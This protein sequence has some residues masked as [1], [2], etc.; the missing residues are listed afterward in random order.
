MT[1]QDFID[2]IE[3]EDKD[4][5]Y[6]FVRTDNGQYYSTYLENGFIAI[7]WDYVTVHDITT[8]TEEE[9]K[10]KISKREKQRESQNDISYKTQISRIYNKLIRFK[11]L[12]KGDIIVIPDEGSYNLAFGE[13]IEDHIFV[14][15]DA[16]FECRYYKRRKVKWYRSGPI[17]SFDPH[18]RFIKRNM[19]AI[20]DVESFRPYIDNVLNFLYKRGD[21]SHYVIEVKLTENI[22][23]RAFTDLVNGIEKVTELISQSFN[24]D[25]DLTDASI[26]LQLQ[27]PGMIEIIDKGS[28]LMI[29]A[30]FLSFASCGNNNVNL[31]PATTEKFKDI[32]QNNPAIVDTCLK[33]FDKLEADK[34]ELDKL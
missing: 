6:W 20:S 18:L 25:E 3:K 28:R 21:Y 33:A 19:H 31:D 7:G 10:A 26:K 29:L 4:R 34:F 9:V 16:G 2:K 12:K 17:N 5:K 13:I 23:L 22:N 32:Q 14:D 15:S 24:F 8:M 27:S 11:E 1:I 30:A